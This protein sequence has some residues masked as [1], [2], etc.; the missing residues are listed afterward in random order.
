MPDADDNG[1]SQ[2]PT[3]A[4]LPS[5]VRQGIH[6]ALVRAPIPTSDMGRRVVVLLYHSIHPSK[7]FASATPALFKE[8]LAWIQDHCDVV[9]FEDSLAVASGPRRD[10]PRVAIAFDDGYADGHTHALPELVERGVQATFFLTLGMMERDPAVIARMAQLQ[11]AT[12][13]EVESLSWTQVLEMQQAGMT[14]GSHGAHHLN[15]ALADDETVRREA[16]GSKDRLE[17]GLGADVSCF[18]YPFG[19]PK[20]HYTRRTMDLVAACGYRVAGTTTYR[21][22]R[23]TD[24]PMAIP[25]ISIT[26]DPIEM[27]EAKVRGRLDLIGLYQSYAPAWASRVISPETSVVT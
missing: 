22:V 5:G 8:H 3:K 4:L 16:R 17:D 25:R 9:R 27:L 10:R 13:E 26:H 23:S 11:A 6:R 12:A 20:V 15:L 24:D 2:R 21:R 18:A 14:F 7:P 19:K 1:R